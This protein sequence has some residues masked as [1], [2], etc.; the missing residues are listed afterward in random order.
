MFS[1]QGFTDQDI[2]K[3]STAVKPLTCEV[4]NNDR[5][6][7]MQCT[8]GKLFCGLHAVV[9]LRHTT[10][11]NIITGHVHPPFPAANFTPN[12]TTHTSQKWHL[13]SE[14]FR[15]QSISQ[16]WDATWNFVHDVFT[17]MYGPQSLKHLSFSQCWHKD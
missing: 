7:T 1:H 10:H 6:I 8:A 2:H 11:L 16:S 14:L 17:Q 13:A 4:N 12:K 3:L 9:T 15:S 5:F